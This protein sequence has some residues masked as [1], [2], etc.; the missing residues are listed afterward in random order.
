VAIEPRRTMELMVLVPFFLSYPIPIAVLTTCLA[1]QR[2]RGQNIRGQGARGQNVGGRGRRGQGGW[3]RLIS[4]W[5]SRPLG[6]L[7]LVSSRPAWEGIGRATTRGWPAG[8]TAPT[9]YASGSLS[10]M[11]RKERHV[12]SLIRRR[13]PGQELCPEGLSFRRQLCHGLVPPSISIT[14]V[15]DCQLGRAVGPAVHPLPSP[16]PGA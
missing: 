15:T 6:L 10:W 16:A 4:S 1:K 5:L 9:G 7:S 13:Y 11:Y 8:P 14:S 12:P 2:T 3:V